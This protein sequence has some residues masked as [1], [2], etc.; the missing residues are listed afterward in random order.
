MRRL[1]FLQVPL[2]ILTIV[3]VTAC[4][5]SGPP[6]DPEAP[7]PTLER[8]RTLATRALDGE[9]PSNQR[10]QAR[11]QA[12][13]AMLAFLREPESLRVT[14]GEW[15]EPVPTGKGALM[16]FFESG[17]VRLH[18]LQLPAS[19]IVPPGERVVVQFSAGSGSP[20]AFELQTLPGGTAVGARAAEPKR[21]QHTLTVAFSLLR[22]GG[23]VAH[24][25]RDPKSGDFKLDAS[26][27][28]GIPNRVGNLTLEVKENFLMVSSPLDIDWRPRFDAKHPLRLFLNADVGLDWKEG[29]VIHDER[30]QS[31]MQWIATAYDA[32]AAK[33]DREEAWDKAVHKLP[34][35]LQEPESWTDQLSGLPPGAK[36]LTDRTANVEVR[37]IIIPAPQVTGANPIM[38]LQQRV[39]GGLPSAQAISLPGAAEALRLFTREGLPALVVVTASSPQVRQLSFFQLATGN[40]WQPAPG[41]FGFLPESPNLKLIHSPASH[42]LVVQADGTGPSVTISDASSPGVQICQ[43]AEQCLSL[44]WMGGKLTST[45]WVVDLVRTSVSAVAYE[46]VSMAADAVKQFLLAPETADLSAQQLANALGR[47]EGIDIQVFDAGSGSR[48]VLMP[49]NAWRVPP[50]LIHS[51]KLVLVEAPQSGLVERWVGI[52]TVEAGGSRWLLLT[53][54]SDETAAI[55]LFQWEGGTWKQV[56]ALAEAVD[57]P[58]GPSV[59]VFYTPGQTGP[60][61]G[62]HA[63]GAPVSLLTSFLPD[64]SGVSICEALYTCAIFRF[65]PAAGRWVL[66]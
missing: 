29:F 1:R 52:R 20:Q 50:A 41:W 25:Q 44:V 56:N 27:F 26:A 3:A 45:G 24:Y 36:I 13:A 37:L 21:D 17:P 15:E 53:G 10:A 9:L 62:I 23:Y 30:S 8:F 11:D 39:G 4:G 43:G 5:R 35:Y 66:K 51:G 19:G 14:R 22:G 42:I 55:L 34:V 65:D 47:S 46:Q 38:L 28:K 6:V 60:V 7:R 32:K 2:L 33:A 48:V 12:V 64:G 31:A 61:R 49:P 63:K 59:K 58:L 54:R 57:R 16:R 18:A 40:D